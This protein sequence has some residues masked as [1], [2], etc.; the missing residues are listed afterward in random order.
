MTYGS[1]RWLLSS[2]LLAGGLS[3]CWSFAA[4]HRAPLNEAEFASYRQDGTA[5]VSGEVAVKMRAGDTSNGAE[6]FVYLV[7]VTPYTT[8]WF[9][10]YI[11]RG[12]R[13]TG[14]DPRS[15]AAIRAT[16]VGPDGRFRFRNLPSGDYYLSC[17][18]NRSTP[19]FR[20]GR[21]KFASPSVERVEAYARVAVKEGEEGRVTLTRPAA[22]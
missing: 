18:V 19:P 12:R 3:G 17:T 1:L 5:I 10:Q 9:E 6:S 8:E 22:P 7:P 20:M 14:D 15:L 2:A 16:I 13:I 11:V 4:D 21:I